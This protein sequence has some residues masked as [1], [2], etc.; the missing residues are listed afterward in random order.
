MQT[1]A[2]AYCDLPQDF[3]PSEFRIKWA[4]GAW[5]RQEAHRLRRAVFCTEQGLFHGDDIDAIDARAQPIVATACVGGMTDQVVG[6]VRIH[7]AEP[8]LWWG[9]RLA[10]HSGFR[11]NVGL[12]TTLIRLAV[13]SAHARGARIFLAH[14]Q[15]QNLALFE[16]LHWTALKQ[17]TLHG[18]SHHLMQADLA[19]YP[20]CYD[21]MTGY[22]VRPKASR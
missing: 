10:V 20:P 5:E 2:D 17:E 12:A 9:S 16:H 6:C 18:R 22:V 11:R 3:A 8:A 13:S 1:T 7:Q 4:D 14:V 15:S 21:V 19:F